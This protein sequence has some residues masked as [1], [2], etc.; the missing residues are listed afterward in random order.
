MS[1]LRSPAIFTIHG[2]RDTVVPYDQATSFHQALDKNG[3]K[4]QLLTL[5]GGTHGGFSDGQYQEAF[6]KIFSILRETGID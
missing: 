3:V 2:N 5:M 4:N 1:M 6:T